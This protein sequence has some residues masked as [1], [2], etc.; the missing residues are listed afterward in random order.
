MRCYLR[1]CG[2]TAS[3]AQSRRKAGCLSSGCN[4]A[5]GVAAK[6]HR[7]G[8]QRPLDSVAPLVKDNQP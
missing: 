7:A 4:A 5:G 1:L 8:L 6:P 3:K 2:D